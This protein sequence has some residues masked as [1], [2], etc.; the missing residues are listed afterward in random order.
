MR[1]LRLYNRLSAIQQRWFQIAIGLACVFTYISPYLLFGEGLPVLIHDN[2]DQAPIQFWRIYH[3]TSR[4]WRSSVANPMFMNGAPSVV[5]G[6][7]L[8]FADLPYYFLPPFAAYV[9]LQLLTRIIAFVGM[10]LLL[11]SM[12]FVGENRENND[13]I[14]TG[15]AILYAILPHYPPTTFSVP[16]LPLIAWSLLGV[17]QRK[18]QWWQWG[19]LC[20]IP[21][22]TSF[23]L[24]PAFLIILAGMMWLFDAIVQRRINWHCFGA[25]ALV[26]VL[27]CISAYDLVVGCLNNNFISHRVEFQTTGISFKTAFL[28]AVS[29]FCDGQ[30][31]VATYHRYLI[32]LF[33][34]TVVL[35]LTDRARYFKCHFFRD[36]T[37]NVDTVW[38]RCKNTFYMPLGITVGAFIL[39]GVI[40]FWYGLYQWLPIVSLRQ[41]VSILNMVQWDRVHWLHPLVWYVGLAGLLLVWGV[42]LWP[43]Y[44][45][46][47]IICVLLFQGLI[48]FRQADYIKSALAK[49]PNWRE[50]YA[51][52]QFEMIRTFIGKPVEKYRV[53]SLGLHPSIA[54]YNGFYCL[55]GYCANY[56]LTYKK[57]FRRIIARELEKSETLGSYFDNWGSRCYLF[58]SEVKKNFLQTKKSAKNI[59]RLDLD[60]DAFRQLGGEYI[61]SAVQIN[62]PEQSGLKLLKMFEHPQS[63]WKIWLYAPLNV[64]G[65]KEQ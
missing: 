39:A 8:Y 34:L 53:V 9:I 3:E 16:A 29:S 20:L 4:F 41:T 50:F 38:D 35:A 7:N 45:R 61:F 22:F 31:H 1:I 43:R 12:F 25:L 57:S 15:V 6:P 47:F 48:L 44:G 19:V 26:S 13:L 37:T 51:T 59:S 23:L 65:S 2:M 54:L 64:I 21:F 58:S 33:I 30:Y 63:A 10:W 36:S 5:G 14:Y 27:Y 56:S 40:S 42:M 18:D 60:L 17:T 32:P 28:R 55:D 49:N 24:A 52:E 11:R 62:N 46:F